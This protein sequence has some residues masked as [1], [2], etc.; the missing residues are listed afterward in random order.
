MSLPGPVS[1]RA[2]NQAG[3]ACFSALVMSSQTA[4]QRAAGLCRQPVVACQGGLFP[5]QFR[6]RGLAPGGGLGA[7]IGE[8]FL[9]RGAGPVDGQI[10]RAHV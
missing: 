7:A 4:F 2:R 9:E 6:A 5:R 10:G 1:T 3:R 8:G